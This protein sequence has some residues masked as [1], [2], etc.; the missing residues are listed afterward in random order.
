MKS[1]NFSP[2]PLKEISRRQSKH[3]AMLSEGW[4]QVLLLWLGRKPRLSFLLRWSESKFK[5]SQDFFSW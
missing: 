2:F 5:A 1:N 4:E 3:F